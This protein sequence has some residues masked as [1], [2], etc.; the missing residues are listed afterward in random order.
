MTTFVDGTLPVKTPCLVVD[1]DA[2]AF[3]V[4]AMARVLP[5]LRLRPHV[6]AFKC[7]ELAKRLA[8]KGHTG[9]TCATLAEVAGMIDAGLGDD[10]LLANET[11]NVEQMRQVVA[12][13]GRVTIA[14]DSVETIAA[15]AEAG[16]NEVLIDDSLL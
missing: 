1:A 12:M 6:K 7:T 9:F 2:F 5:G 10:L 14:V 3:N 13:P 8:G 15:A 11:L 16:V 4:D